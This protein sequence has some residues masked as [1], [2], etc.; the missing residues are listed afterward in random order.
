MYQYRS[1]RDPQT[2]LRQCVYQIA[3]IRVRYGYRKIRVLLQREDYQV[4]KNRLYRLYREEGQPL[5]CRPNRKRRAQM[6]RPSL[7]R[8]TAAN[9]AWSPEFFADQLAGGQ[10]SRAMTI[11]DV[12]TREAPVQ[13]LGALDAVR[14]LEE[15]RIRSGT[16]RTLLCD[17]G[18]ELPVRWWICGPTITRSK[19]PSAGPACQRIMRSWSPSTACFATNVRTLKTKIA[20]GTESRVRS[21]NLQL[22]A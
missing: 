20:F 2:A 19:L 9:H 6:S 8:A 3:A 17:N 11:V 7:A 12:F 10:L 15:L 14:A 13:R 1:H 18:S 16:P 21:I 4:S 5:R 22:V